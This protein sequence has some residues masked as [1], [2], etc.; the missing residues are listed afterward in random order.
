MIA[1]PS[2]VEYIEMSPA[3]MS[4]A[5]KPATTAVSASENDPTHGIT[6]HLGFTALMTR[7]V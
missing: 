5:A 4:A 3:T 2:A 6:T 7:A 1:F